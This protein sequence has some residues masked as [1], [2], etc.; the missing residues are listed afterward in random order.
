MLYEGATVCYA[1]ARVGAGLRRSKTKR[2]VEGAAG[3]RGADKH[4]AAA[5]FTDAYAPR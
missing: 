1:A 5:A 4:F 3:T 2:C